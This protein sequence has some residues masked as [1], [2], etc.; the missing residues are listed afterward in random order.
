MSD[1]Y[2]L[3]LSPV[4]IGNVTLKNRLIGSKCALQAFTVEQAKEFYVY[5]AKNGAATVTVAM[6]DYPHHN[7]NQNNGHMDGTG[8]DVRDPEVRKGFEELCKAVHEHGTLVSASMMDIEPTDVGISDCPNWDEIPKK[9]DYNTA[10]FRNK[11]GISAEG[12]QKVIDEFVFRAKDFKDMGFDMATFY[13]SYRSSILATSMSPVFNQRTDKYGGS[14]MAERATL[15]REVFTRIK[16]ACGEDFLIEAQISAIEEEP[17][18]DLEG[19]L[20]YCQAIED[21]VDIIQIRGIDGSATHVN[22]LNMEKGHP[23]NLDYAEAFK[24]RGI[25]ALCAPVGGFGNPDDMERFLEEGKS[26]LFAMARQFLADDEYYE[27]LKA[28][29]GSEVIPCIMCNGCHGLHTCSVNPRAGRLNDFPAETTPKTVAIIGGGPAGLQA[30]YSAAQRGHKVTLFEKS[31]SLGGQVKAAVVAEYKWPLKDF[32]DYLIRKC[33]ENGVEFKLGVEADADM[34]SGKYD[35]VIVAVGSEPQSIPVE[36]ADGKNVH[37][38]EDV[39]FCEEKLGKNVVVIG[40]SWTGRDAALYLSRKGHKVTMV[41]R[42]RVSL[43]GDMHTQR[44]EEE[45]FTENPNFSYIDFASTEKIGDGCVVLNVRTNPPQA[46]A[47]GMFGASDDED[48]KIKMH[49]GPPP[50]GEGG[51]GGPGG[52][53]GPGGPGGPGGHGGPGGPFGGAPAKEEPPVYELRTIECDDVVISGGRKPREDVAKQFENAAP[54]VFKV[55]DLTKVSN[56]KSAI[57]AGHKAAMLI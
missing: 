10:V 34:I 42:S 27:K 13:M 37:L 18:Y 48:T 22:G 14:T 16:E 40:G 23:S 50:G 57:Y 39:F 6:P 31:D 36:G 9:G 17:G 33:N 35:A 45:S 20:D 4:K 53:D 15:A 46:P 52:P 21:C 47:F 51:P 25:K 54:V 1:K 8:L 30:A 28:G 24:K 29:Q 49:M 7:L 41:T 12:L 26:D 44:L 38:A 11:P 3:L 5:L 32:L 2:K 56:V 19:F 55:G 43:S